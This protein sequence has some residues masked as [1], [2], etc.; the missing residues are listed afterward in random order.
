MQTL[1]DFEGLQAN[2][3]YTN[4]YASQGVLMP[5]GVFAGAD[6][7]V[8][9]SGTKYVSPYHSDF[10]VSRF[11]AVFLPIRQK[12]VSLYVGTLDPASAVVGILRAYAA[13]GSE[14][15]HDGPRLVQALVC[16]TKFEVSTSSNQISSIWMEMFGLDANGMAFDPDQAAD[17]LQFE[18][19]PP[20]PIR[21]INVPPPTFDPNW[22]GDTHGGL[23]PPHGVAPWDIEWLRPFEIALELANAANS[24]HE[25]IRAKAR[26]LA[27]DQGKVA[28]EAMKKEM[29]RSRRA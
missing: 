25:N 4:A 22:P 3:F 24:G 5:V 18:A 16:A 23:T 26:D 20:R 10:G 19:D 15:T 9:H 2:H 8:A 28:L 14:I 11:Q 12:R 13:N 27:V 29:D 17:D 1:I 6:P 21:R 7:G